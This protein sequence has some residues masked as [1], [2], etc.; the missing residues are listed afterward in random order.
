MFAK[1]LRHAHILTSLQG[2]RYL[3]YDL[4]ALEASIKPQKCE[5]VFV[6]FQDSE[7]FDSSLLSDLIVLFQYV[8]SNFR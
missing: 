6:A 1:S 2:R 8:L 5:H 3:D 7:G 4:E